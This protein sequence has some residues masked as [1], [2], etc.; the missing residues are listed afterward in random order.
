MVYVLQSQQHP[1]MTKTINN[2]QHRGLKRETAK[3]RQAV[4]R[5]KRS[6]IINPVQIVSQSGATASPMRQANKELGT[7]NCT[8]VV[9]NALCNQFD[10]RIWSLSHQ[11]GWSEELNRIF[12]SFLFYKKARQEWKA[13]ASHG[14]IPMLDY[15]LMRKASTEQNYFQGETVLCLHHNKCVYLCVYITEWQKWQ[16][17]HLVISIS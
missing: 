4:I 14:V 8:C 16:Q 17:R 1:Q 11:L 6:N 7:E 2:Q 3:L 9:I 12:F 10:H 15:T 13:T 5:S